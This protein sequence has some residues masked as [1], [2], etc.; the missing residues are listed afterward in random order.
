[1]NHATKYLIYDAELSK[2]QLYLLTKGRTKSQVD[3]FASTEHNS[4]VQ[5]SESQERD[6]EMRSV[7]K[8]GCLDLRQTCYYLCNTKT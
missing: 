4:V 6:S 8:L 5:E 7:L 1:M 2:E 3:I